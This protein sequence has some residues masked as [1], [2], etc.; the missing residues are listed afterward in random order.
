MYVNSV[1]YHRIFWIFWRCWL[2]RKC[3][4]TEH[5]L[6]S[7]IVCCVFESVFVFIP[8]L[9]SAY[10]LHM[11]LEMS[12]CKNDIV[13]RKKH[14]NKMTYLLLISTLPSIGFTNTE[15]I[16]FKPKFS[17]CIWTPRSNVD[18]PWR[19]WMHEKRF[20]DNCSDISRVQFIIY[21]TV[22][23]CCVYVCAGLQPWAKIV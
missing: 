22:N 13:H 21:L 6:E 4:C 20:N 7:Y 8:A 23:T 3:V 18:I 10:L 14:Y 1:V 19:A 5:K 17:M 15:V 11:E 12:S 16:I 9:C 2:S